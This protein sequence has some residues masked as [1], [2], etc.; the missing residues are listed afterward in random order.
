[1]GGGVSGL[2]AAKVFERG[3]TVWTGPAAG[4]TPEITDRY[5]GV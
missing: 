5:L 2:A 4:L 3:R 1:M